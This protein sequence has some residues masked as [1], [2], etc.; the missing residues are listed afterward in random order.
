M[1]RGRISPKT[2]Q[3]YQKRIRDVVQ[4]LSR[5]VM[6]YLPPRRAECPNCYYDKLTGKSTGK[7]KWTVTEAEAEQA[8]WEAAGNTTIRYKYFKR[9][10]CPVCMGKG[11]IETIRRTWADCLV[12][13]NPQNRYNNELTYTPAGTE[14]STLVQLKT[15]PKNYDNFKNCV[16][17]FVDNVECKLARPPILRG[18]G[19]QALLIIVAFTTEKPKKDSDE[20]IKDYSS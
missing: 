6:I 18:L 8:A 10:R 2:K 11:Q 14:G 13:W 3:R 15:D 19:N 16:R 12:T 1:V 7:C 17:I 9:G 5:K 4:G 20:T